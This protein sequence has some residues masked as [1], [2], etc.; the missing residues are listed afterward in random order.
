MKKGVLLVG[1]VL[2]LQWVTG[3]VQIDYQA[4]YVVL[5]NNDTVYGELK[6]LP[7]PSLIS[8]VQFKEKGTSHDTT[9]T[10]DAIKSFHF[11]PNTTFEAIQIKSINKKDTS[12]R[13]YFALRKLTGV[14]NFFILYLP[15]SDERYFVSNTDYGLCELKQPLE[16]ISDQVFSNKRY[17]STLTKYLQDVPALQSKIQNCSFYEGSMLNLISEYNGHFGPS[18]EQPK[19]LIKY[20]LSVTGG[21][22][23][24]L[25]EKI[26]SNSDVYGLTLGLEASF[27]NKEKNM[28]SE[29]VLGVYYH[30][31]VCYKSIHA[32]ALGDTI[33]ITSPFLDEPIAYYLKD[34][35]LRVVQTGHML[36]VPMFLRYNNRLKQISPII[37]AG[38]EPFLLQN[39][40]DAGSLGT[41]H[42]KLVV[43]FNY[44]IG[45][46]VGLNQEKFRLKYMIYADPFL[47]NTLSIQFKL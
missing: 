26:N 13:S 20:D 5:L 45:L 2:L 38:I 36:G 6:K 27:S 11:D 9:Y 8:S 40:F 29:F 17:L 25:G 18:V 16:T 7:Y 12:D 1:M 14:V 42:S 10:A 33:R 24:Y 39:S 35:T 4:G 19:K 3:Q 23:Y 34:E 46:G 37:E 28:K 22:D 44:I 32:T 21:L 43:D 15:N 41:F 30:T 47:Q 31:F